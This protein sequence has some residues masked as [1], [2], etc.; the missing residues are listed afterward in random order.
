M[1]RKLID[2]D[3]APKKVNLLDILSDGGGNLYSV[4]NITANEV[5]AKG[6][7]TKKIIT[8]NKKDF[9]SGNTAYH[10]LLTAPVKIYNLNDQPKE[11]KMTKEEVKAP[12]PVKEVA[13][14]PE[15]TTEASG[16]IRPY[17]RK[18]DEILNVA[19]GIGASA[20]QYLYDLVSEIFR[21]G[22]DEEFEGGKDD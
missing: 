13:K 8:I 1:R 16:G 12:E 7:V 15:P 20:E 14:I 9:L 11:E 5:I 22:F 6:I 19:E 3:L 18:I 10:R 4:I 2:L 17:L 21:N